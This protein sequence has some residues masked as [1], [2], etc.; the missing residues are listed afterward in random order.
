MTDGQIAYSVAKLK[1]YGVVNSGDALKL[2]IGA[3]TDARVKA[4]FDEMVKVGLA[5][6]DTRLQEGLHA[7]IRK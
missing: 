5:K 1:A 2:G 6:P 4:F 3:M 7:A